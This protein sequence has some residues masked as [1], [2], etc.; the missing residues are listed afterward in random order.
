PSPTPAPSPYTLSLH[1][2]LPIYPISRMISLLSAF[3]A[4]VSIPNPR[5][6][7]GVEQVDQQIDHHERDRDKQDAALQQRVISVGDRLQDQ[8]THTGQGKD[9]LNHHRAAEEIPDL[10]AENRH[11]RDQGVPQGV[12]PNDDPLRRPLDPGHF[13]I[14]LV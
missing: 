4:E 12:A 10:D 13:D 6:D 7:Q 11:H 3:D 1:D 14:F 9:L 2:A 8:L 5:M